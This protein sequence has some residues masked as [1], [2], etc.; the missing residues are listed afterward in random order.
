[1]SDTDTVPQTLPSEI[2]LHLLV[3]EPEVIAELVRQ[4]I[5]AARDAFALSALRLGVLALR[6]AS[7]MLDAGAIRQEGERLLGS[8]RQ[9]LTEELK[10]TSGRLSDTLS[11]Y[12]DPND[13]QL[14]QRLERLVRK[15][16]EL[17]TLLARQLSGDDCTI[18]RTLA[19][20]VGEQ[21]PLLRMLSPSQ[22]DGLLATLGKALEE[23]LRAQR[24]HILRQFSLD[25]KA[26]AL[27][28]L[29][30][31]MC[32]ANGKLKEEFA[33]DLS[34]VRDEFSL[35]N[36]QGA[37]SRLVR[38]VEKAQQLITSEFSMD[39][40]ASA[41]SRMSKLLEQTNQS[42]AASLT[43]DD[44][45]S[46]LSRLRRELLQVVQ[47]LAKAHQE[48]H[49]EVSTT[50]SALNARREE[51]LRSTR[52]GGEFEDAVGEIVRTEAQRLN[53]LY[54]HVGTKTGTKPYCRK[55]DHLVLLGQESAAPGARIIFEAK[56]DQAYSVVDALAE[57]KEC[58]ENR[59]AQAGVFVFS[60]RTCPAGLEPI[61]RHGG[62]LVIVW[63][64]DDPASDLYLKAGY[65]IARALVVRQ[66]SEASQSAADF[67]AIDGAVISIA[68]NAAK[69]SEVGTF[70]TTIHN[71]SKKIME[72]TDK[73]RETIERQLDT[74]REHLDA[75]RPTRATTSAA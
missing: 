49:N 51:A 41:L 3:R 40:Q 34:K 1:M 72:R 17:E 50:L 33:K 54:E 2:D 18:A 45:K 7:G 69:L 38:R 44:E 48:F 28:R 39:N 13:G 29:V 61:A 16:G 6:Q 5:G 25:D 24:E 65:W 19:R 37:L 36:E 12:F 35:D 15:D 74:L 55:G 66:Q 46:P 58:R 53:D 30:A 64:R 62:D 27:S 22:S 4:P 68:D 31:E 63:D 47:E 43:L 70:A 56:E 26:S 23:A 14:S 67:A 21:S 75:L 9:L 11:R 52:H 20:H 32:G 57:L 10:T 73:I 60:C 42:I 59:Q 71:N 8:V